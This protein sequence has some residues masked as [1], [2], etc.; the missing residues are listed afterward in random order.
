MSCVHRLRRIAIA[1]AVVVVLVLVAGTALAVWSVRRSFPTTEGRVA[2]TGLTND[3]RV[4]RDRYGVPHVYAHNAEDLFFAQGYVQAQDRFFQMDFRRHVASGRLAE[5]FGPPALHSDMLVRTM[6]WRAVAEREFALLDA[7]TRRYLE[8]FSEGVNAYLQDHA[9]SQ[10]SLEYAVLGL[11]GLNYRPE[12]WT[13]VDSL[14][15]LKAMAWDLRS[16]MQDEV[17]RTLA[18]S[19]LPQ[20]RIAG[21]YPRYPERRH[22]PVV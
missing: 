22:R 14:V 20:R 13:P 17:A 11:G 18:S 10:I 6:G 15:W 21:L 9:P 16:N 19:V 12:E 8:A 1:V 5:L 4:V 2:V 7:D 3:V